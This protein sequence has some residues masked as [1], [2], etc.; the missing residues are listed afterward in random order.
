MY[1]QYSY[2]TQPLEENSREKKPYYRDFMVFLM[3]Y[4]TI[5]SVTKLISYEGNLD[6]DAIDNFC[7]KKFDA[8]GDHRYLSLREYFRGTDALEII[9]FYHYIYEL[10]EEFSKNPYLFEIKMTVLRY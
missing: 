5:E 3:S 4:S 9:R 6:D 2:L 7:R 10:E 8:L 1:T